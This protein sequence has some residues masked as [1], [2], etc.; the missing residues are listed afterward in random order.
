[1]QRLRLNKSELHRLKRDLALYRRVLPALELKREALAA[2]LARERAAAREAAMALQRGLDAAARR[3][4]MAAN[5]AI[6]LEDLARPEPARFGTDSVMGA[7]LP[8]LES[9]AWRPARHALLARPAWVEEAAAE[10]R[11]LAGALMQL[12]TLERRVALLE[13]SLARATQRVNLFE[14]VLLPRAAGAARRIEVALGDQERAA[15][16]R[17]KMT[18]RRLE[19]R[20]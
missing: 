14:K 10:V 17:S 1:M 15:L 19:E 9:P 6:V 11:S 2:S 4:P 16:T 13:R 3:L 18:K 8:R 20:A 12:R 7:V 5:E